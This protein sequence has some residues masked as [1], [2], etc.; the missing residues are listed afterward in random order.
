MKVELSPKNGFYDWNEIQD[1]VK[2]LENLGWTTQVIATLGTF[3]ITFKKKDEE[4]EKK[5]GE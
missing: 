3:R 4:D 2:A 1:V 5:R